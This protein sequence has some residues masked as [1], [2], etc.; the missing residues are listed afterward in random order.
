MQIIQFCMGLFG[1][2]MFDALNPWLTFHIPA[3]LYD[4]SVL[5]QLSSLGH[6]Y[7]NTDHVLSQT[8]I[9]LQM[10]KNTSV[11]TQTFP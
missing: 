10:N 8:L 2:I 11:L 1:F 6:L 4:G 9:L 3:C 5:Y 7:D